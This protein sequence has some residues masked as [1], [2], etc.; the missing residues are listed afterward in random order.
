[1]VGIRYVS[2]MLFLHNGENG[3]LTRNIQGEK[4]KTPTKIFR[5]NIGVFYK[6]WDER[7]PPFNNPDAKPLK[8]SIKIQNPKERP[9]VII[10]EFGKYINSK[11]YNL[12][13]TK[14]LAKEYYRDN[15]DENIPVY[16]YKL[17][18][19]NN[20]Y[21]AIDFLEKNGVLI[22]TNFDKFIHNISENKWT[23][24]QKGK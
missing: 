10:K 18:D 14:K 21:N 3:M 7:Y 6:G 15:K 11:R 16:R 8:K 24:K 22:K 12:T 1:M 17:K 9:F 5:N 23:L 13:E 20:I 4:L 2:D 19:L